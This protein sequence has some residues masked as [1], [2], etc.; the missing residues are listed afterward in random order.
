M[1]LGTLS[2]H[3]DSFIGGGKGHQKKGET[4]VNELP[5]P[6][7]ECT[8]CHVDGRGVGH[9]LDCGWKWE[10]E[11]F[12]SGF[13]FFNL[14]IYGLPTAWASTFISAER[15]GSPQQHRVHSKWSNPTA[16]CQVLNNQLQ[17][18]F[19]LKQYPPLKHVIN[20]VNWGLGNR[21]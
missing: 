7:K 14:Y 1:F 8:F 12:F 10:G 18:T 9:G 17:L 2:L 21:H 19:Y 5:D 11:T 15:S 6:K 4:P 16:E 20:I 13:N 3:W